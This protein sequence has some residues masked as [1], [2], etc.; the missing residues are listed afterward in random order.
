[1][2]P[3]LPPKKPRKAYARRVPSPSFGDPNGSLEERCAWMRSRQTGR[4]RPSAE[5]CGHCAQ[6]VAS[7]ALGIGAKAAVTLPFASCGRCVA[8]PDSGRDRDRTD[9]VTANPVFRAERRFPKF[10]FADHSFGI[11]ATLY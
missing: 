3:V 5:G 11:L 1:M 6:I 4:H 2:L 10:L 8:L 7:L 9:A